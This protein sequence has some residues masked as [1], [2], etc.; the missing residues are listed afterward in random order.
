MKNKIR[1][2]R[3]EVLTVVSLKIYNTPEM[4]HCVLG[5]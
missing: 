1:N 5:K 4:W 3:F 2:A